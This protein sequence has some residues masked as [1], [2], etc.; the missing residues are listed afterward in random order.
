M[1]GI[2]GDIIIILAGTFLLLCIF[3]F[4]FFFV[5]VYNKRYRKYEAEK[6]EMRKQFELEKLQS[7]LEIQ[8][9]TLKNISG[10]IHDNIGQILSLVGLQISTIPTNKPEKI[11]QTSELLD[12]AI[13]DLRNLS[14]RLDTDRITSIG[15]IE[16]ITHEMKVIERTGKFATELSIEADF[17]MLSPDKTIIL[18]RIIQEILNNII[19]HSKAT[20]IS[21][22]LKDNDREDVLIIEDN[23][24][25]FDMKAMEG[26]GLGLNNIV[27]RAKLIGGNATINSSINNGT[28]ITFK[29]PKKITNHV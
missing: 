3:G 24:I 22:Q 19:K 5:I 28:S 20:K 14:K 11:D 26:K 17:E 9:Q 21:I 15:I 27:N 23:G 7:Q 2:G 13:E 18:Y 8:E 29:I 16:A 12:R 25:G 4:I 10:E 6:V 1:Q